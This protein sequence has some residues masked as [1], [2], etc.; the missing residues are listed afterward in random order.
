MVVLDRKKEHL[1][2]DIMVILWIEMPGASPTGFFLGQMGRY[3]LIFM[4]S[5]WDLMWRPWVYGWHVSL[6]QQESPKLPMD[7]LAGM[8]LPFIDCFPALDGPPTGLF[9]TTLH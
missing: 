5:L 3:G 7:V 1:W 6:D 4:V 9:D 2:L 8:I